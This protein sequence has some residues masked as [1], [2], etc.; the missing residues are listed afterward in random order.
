MDSH[1]VF[2]ESFG[3]TWPGGQSI[4][5]R[6]IC[7]YLSKRGHT[8]WHLNK[9]MQGGEVK[10]SSVFGE[11]MGPNFGMLGAWRHPSMYDIIPFYLKKYRPDDFIT[12]SD[13]WDMQDT[14][15]IRDQV[16]GSY[17]RWIHNL[18]FD[19]QNTVGIWH[20]T[21]MEPDIPWVSTRFVE[22][23]LKLEFP[24][25]KYWYSTIGTTPD[26][27]KPVTESKK[28]DLREKH[29]LPPDGPILV[30]VAMS[31]VRKKLDRV[32]AML[33]HLKLR[34][35]TPTLYLVSEPKS[36]MGWDLDIISEHYK[37]RGQIRYPDYMVNQM[38]H[39]WVEEKEMAEY[40]Q[41]GDAFVLLNG[42]GGFE[43]PLVEAMSTGL[44]IITTNYCTGTEFC[45]TMSPEGKFVP[46]TGYPVPYGDIEHH[47]QGGIWALA[48]IPAAA[49][50]TAHVLKNPDEARQVGLRARQKVIDNYNWEK[51][52]PQWDDLIRSTTRYDNR[53]LFETK[54]VSV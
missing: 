35:L 27:F 40:Y 23:R 25:V 21:I 20:P 24:W 4:I 47:G 2:F 53:R 3:A 13:V 14:G 9:W 6:K 45:H 41:L 32:V 8:V 15:K 22:D 49:D 31:Q 51:I 39:K 50:I 48:N 43:I 29:G 52:L 10:C 19:T 38:M 28:R 17:A 1:T 16:R 42:G 34:G 12:Y 33:A 26:V 7:S 5:A 44:P 30:C 36:K 18:C 54:A 11:E 37:V 46:D